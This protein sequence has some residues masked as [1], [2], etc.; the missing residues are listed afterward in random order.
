MK[1][2]KQILLAAALAV[3]VSVFGGVTRDT[4]GWTQI[5]PSGDS[6][7]VYVSS[8][9]GSDSNDGL[10]S[11]TPKAT[12]SA[13][14][15]LVRD[16]YPDHLLLKRGDTFTLGSG[17]LGSWKNGRSATEPIVFSYYGTS[18]A[19]PVVKIVDRFVDHNGNVRNYQA[20]VGVEIYKSN[21][22]PSSGDYTGASGTE[23]LRFVGGG[24]N[25]RIEDCRIR[26]VQI[27]IQSYGSGTYS[28]VEV[29][30]NIVLDSWVH[31]SATSQTE[32]QGMYVSGVDD[33]LIE[34]NFFDHNGWNEGISDAAANQFNHDIYVQYDNKAGGIMRGNILARGAAHGLQARSGGEVDRNLCVLNAVGL[35][36]GGVHAPIDPNVLTW[37]NYAHDNVVLNGRLMSTTDSNYPRTT[38]IYGLWEDTYVQDASIDGNIVANRINSGSNLSYHDL[39]NMNFGTNISYNWDP[40]LD[41]T[42]PSWPH[43]GDDLGDY[44]ASI[45][46]ANSTTAYLDTLRNRAPGELPW[47]LTAYAAINYIRAG[48]LMSPVSGVYNYPGGGGGGGGGVTANAGAGFQNTAITSQTGTFTVTFSA[49]PSV[50]QIDSVIGLAAV[51]PTAYTDLAAIARFNASGYIDARDGGAYTADASI[52]YS[53]GQAYAFRLVVDV[54]AKTYSI[55]V[56][57]PGGSEQ[58]VGSNYAFRSEQSGVSS[59]NYWTAQVNTPSGSSVNVNDFAISAGGG[60]SGGV[61]A[62]AGA[63]FQST[64][65]TSQTGTF[66]AA[67]SATPSVSPL[68]SVIGLAMA[69]PSAYTDLAAVAR[70]NP[71]GYIDARNGGA[72]AAASSIPYSSGQTYAFRLVINVPAKTYSIY[73]TPPGGSEQTVGSNYAFRSE[74]SGASSLGYWTA[75]VDSPSGSSVNVNNFT[76]TAG[77]GTLLSFGDFEPN[78]A[79]VLQ[80]MPTTYTLGSGATNIWFGRVG[81][82]SGQN[83]TYQA[84]SGSDHYVTVGTSPNTNGCTQVIAWPGAGSHQVYFSY[85]GTGSSVRI[86]GGNT[87]NT[88]N[89]FDGSNTLTLLATIN[90][91]SSTSW[92]TGSQTVTL[93]GS[94]NYLVIQLRAGD[95]DNVTIAP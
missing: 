54:P 87:G 91:S 51:A 7:I 65:I 90:N 13:G 52:A 10:S 66:T 79:T 74:Q 85:R 31:G 48:F 40:A 18:G 50:S 83:T 69:A 11:S 14:N 70:F 20:F 8:S 27:T 71:S 67:F 45:G 42:N 17:G 43:P 58:T 94:Y 47:N 9:S 61:T 73:V 82:A 57:P 37:P 28:N 77:A 30:R 29:R 23:G 15:A 59:L 49:T 68:D 35:N 25:L 2:Q 21:S 41:T 72:Y 95:F 26:F 24:A 55:Y 44:N 53:G 81:T 88:I 22:D 3:P 36:V 39:S 86:Y 78:Q 84:S 33:Y 1:I 93:T 12:I 63:G 75:Q 92:Q 64:A 76:L 32:I 34:E 56:T 80:D 62:N 46:G 16:G 4:N 89:K 19:R 60:G 5:T 6:R 38:A